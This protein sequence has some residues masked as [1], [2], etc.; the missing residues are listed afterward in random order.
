[1]A[2]VFAVADLRQIMH[3]MYPEVEDERPD[4]DPYEHPMTAI[5]VVVLGAAIMGTTDA[6]RL[7]LF[8]GYSRPFIS[9][10]TLNMQNNQLWVDGR[11]DASSWLSSDGTIAEKCLWDHIEI[12]CGSQWMPEGDTDIE[13][14]TCKIYWDEREHSRGEATNRKD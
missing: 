2:K 14:D 9:A 10:I 5:G 12:A 13:A 4:N 3:G 6:S 1:M 7:M 11:Y 8:T